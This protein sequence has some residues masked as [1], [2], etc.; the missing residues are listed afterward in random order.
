[1]FKRSYN[2][3]ALAIR[4]TTRSPLRIGAGNVG[5][6]PSS[7]DMTP[8][9]SRHARHGTTVYIPGSSLRG[10][11]R[12]AAEA[13]LRGKTFEVASGVEGA[14]DPLHRVDSCSG[15][16]MSEKDTAGTHRQHCLAC[17]LFGSTHIK[18]R[19]AMQDLWPWRGAKDPLPEEEAA[20][21]QKANSVELRHGVAIDRVTGSV[22]HGPFDQEVVPAGVSFWGV[23]TLENYQGWQLGL[24]VAAFDEVTSG[25][26]QLGGG[27][28]T[29]LGM[30]AIEVERIVHEQAGD[31]GDA[32]RGVGDLAGAADV[33]Q[34]G[35]APESRMPK[36]ESV[37]SGLV[38]RFT[39]TGQ[40]SVAPWLEAGLTALRELR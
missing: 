40:S 30:A 8:V 21:L 22:R 3:A 4:L 26:A 5:L 25:F 29:G 12:S 19:A 33:A 38:D 16:K 28:S 36:L 20:N 34:Y 23:V 35:L 31:R 11:L 24:L 39:S 1:M 27:K 37:R 6:D 2:R 32:P 17:R 10:V 14:C 15:K 13:A 18:G 9:R 7:A